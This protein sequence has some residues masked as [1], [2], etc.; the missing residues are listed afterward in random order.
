[1]TFAPP[2]RGEATTTLPGRSVSAAAARNAASIRVIPA[3]EELKA[4]TVEPA[5]DR[6]APRAPALRAASTR[7]G[8]CG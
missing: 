1:M 5:P 8:S 3:T 2:L 4:T 6:H 7:R